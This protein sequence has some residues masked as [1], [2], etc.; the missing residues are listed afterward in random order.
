[1]KESLFIRI[2]SV[3]DRL[4]IVLLTFILP[5]FYAW[6]KMKYKRWDKNVNF[7]LFEIFRPFVLCLYPPLS[8]S[9]HIYIY[10]YIYITLFWNFSTLGSSVPWLRGKGFVC[11]AS[12]HGHRD[13]PSSVT[14]RPT[15]CKLTSYKSHFRILK[16]LPL[17]IQGWWKCIFETLAKC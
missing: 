5:F 11:T 3:E 1:M 10:I 8:L 15:T 6:R 2:R 9:L 13:A 17:I 7:F 4:Q 16:T 12:A 14:C